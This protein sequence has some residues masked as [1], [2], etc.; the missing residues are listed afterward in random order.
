MLPQHLGRA[1]TIHALA[2]QA[3]C[4]S[5]SP[6]PATRSMPTGPARKA[7]ATPQCGAN[8]RPARCAETRGERDPRRTRPAANETPA[9]APTSLA[10]EHAG[11]A[12]RISEDHLND[13]ATGGHVDIKTNRSH[14]AG[15]GFLRLARLVAKDT[16]DVFL[17]TH[18][19]PDARRQ[20]AGQ[21]SE[22]DASRLPPPTRKPALA[23]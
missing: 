11:I 17:R 1:M 16:V 21:G 7:A 23:R 2:D 12:V 20:R 4:S 22:L 19:Q 13:Y 10:G 14:D 3:G 5:S 8:R 15:I 9:V 6:M 18:D